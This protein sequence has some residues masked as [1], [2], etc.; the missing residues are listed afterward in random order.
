MPVVN[1]TRHL[2]N[3]HVVAGISWTA[4]G[5]EDL[6]ELR[7]LLQ[8]GDIK[9]PEAVSGLRAVLPGRPKLEPA[10]ALAEEFDVPVMIHSGDT[11]SPRGR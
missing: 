9:G 2:P 3:I 8:A 11:Y 5:R 4:F 1:A 6:D 7:S 10:Y